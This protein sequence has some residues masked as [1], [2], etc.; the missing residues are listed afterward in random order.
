[1]LSYQHAYHAGNAADVHKHLALVM[2]LRRL[3][4]KEKPF[5]FIDSHAGRGVYDLSSAQAQKTREAEAGVL[6]LALTDDALGFGAHSVTGTR[7]TK[8]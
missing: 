3:K 4:Q 8:R 5:C 7:K 2:L 1:M 6:R